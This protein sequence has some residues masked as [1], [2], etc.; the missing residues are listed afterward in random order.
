M[1]H[2]RSTLLAARK[3]NGLGV[4][5]LLCGTPDQLLQFLLL[6]AMVRFIHVVECSY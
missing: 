6:I 3:M 2:Q 5:G 1:S 4:G